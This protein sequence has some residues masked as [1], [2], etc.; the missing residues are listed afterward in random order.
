[1]ASDP[2]NTWTSEA[3]ERG[4]DEAVE[5]RALND[6]GYLLNRDDYGDTPLLTAISFGNL[7]LVRFLIQQGAD[8]NVEVDD[9]YTCLLSAVE[10]DEEDSV[11]IVDTLIRAGA[12]IHA[13]GTNGWTPLHMAA[14]RGHVDKA[15]LLI[16]S[17]ADVNRRTEIDGCE[18]PLMEAAY[19]GRPGTVRLLLTHG[20]DASMRDTVHDRTPIE[21]AR[22]TADGPDPAVVEYLQNDLVPIDGIDMAQHYIDAS[23][24]LVKSCDHE[25]VI[26][27]LADHEANRR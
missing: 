6:P 23:N 7:R 24:E 3:I 1:M 25:Q 17:G 27:I 15:R 8:P 19:A 10:S 5:A 12:D 18:T 2:K 9:G 4:D 20:A 11:A 22:D 21:I 13:T 26:R 16:Q 14:A